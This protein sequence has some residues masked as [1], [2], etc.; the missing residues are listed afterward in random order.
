MSRKYCISVFIIVLWIIY[1]LYFFEKLGK[2]LRVIVGQIFPILEI[3]NR[4]LNRNHVLSY[5]LE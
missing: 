2:L 1:G 4:I 3:L 5:N